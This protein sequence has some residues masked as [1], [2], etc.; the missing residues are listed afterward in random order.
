MTE[1]FNITY[2]EFPGWNESLYNTEYNPERILNEDYRCKE[3]VFNDE[4]KLYRFL[5]YKTSDGYCIL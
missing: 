4:I 2:E 1:T 5:I 3:S